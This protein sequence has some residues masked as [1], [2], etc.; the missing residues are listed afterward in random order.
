MKIVIALLLTLIAC[1][2]CAI[3]EQV[4]NTPKVGSGYSG[5][6][7]S[8]YV[9]DVNDCS[10][11]ESRYCRE[12]LAAGVDA[13]CIVTEYR[14]GNHAVVRA[15]YS[16]RNVVYY[17]MTSGRRSRCLESFGRY[18][19]TVPRKLLGQVGDRE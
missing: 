2:G 18:K 11:K 15:T 10:N 3:R 1:S 19:Y 4:F 16:L 14:G 7:F 9:E 6:V 13:D 8:R 12:L 5:I 17:D